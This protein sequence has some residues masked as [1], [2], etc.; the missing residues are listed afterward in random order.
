MVELIVVVVILAIAAVAIVPKF[1]GTAR[2]DADNSVER[3]AELLRMFAFRESLGSQQVALWRDP[4]DGRIHL[5]VKDAMGDAGGPPDWRADRFAAPV[6]LVDGLE[7]VNVEVDDD[8]MDPSEWII[9]SVPGG[10]RP[11]VEFRLV[12]HGIDSTVTL[13]GGSPAVVRVDADKPAPIAR[14]PIDLNRQ[15]RSDEPW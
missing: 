3:V 11:Q 12:G 6:A 15:G 4:A 5:L 14:F 10:E 13:P 9:A 2:Q 8:A 1:S 7:L